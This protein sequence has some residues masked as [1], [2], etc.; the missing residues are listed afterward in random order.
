M[1]LVQDAFLIKAF[2]PVPQILTIHI[3]SCF[4]L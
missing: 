1:E 4:R 2:I 3:T